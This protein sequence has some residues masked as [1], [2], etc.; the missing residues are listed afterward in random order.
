MRTTHTRVST[1]V[2]GAVLIVTLLA[3]G[4][5]GTA[6]AQQ[7]AGEVVIARVTITSSE[8]M[9]RLIGLGLDLLEHREGADLFILSTPEQVEELGA[10]GF[11]ISIDEPQTAVL[12]QQIGSLTFRD[13]YSTV[14]EMRARLEARAAQYP[15]LAEFFI[16]GSSWQKLNGQGGHDLFGIRLTNTEIPGPKPTFFLMAAIH[17][18]E[19]TV[20]ELALRFIDH[21]L[22][23]YG[24]DADATWLLDEHVVVVVPVVNPD[25]RRVAEQGY[26]QRKNMNP[27]NGFGCANPPTVTNQFGID[28]NRNYTFKWGTVNGPGEPPCGQTYPGPIP[29]SEPETDAVQGLVRSLFA[30]QRGPGDNDAAPLTTTGVLLTLHSYGDLVLWP[31]GYTGNTAPNVADLSLIGR[32]FAGYNGHTPQQS[33]QLYPT[34]GT[35]DDWSYGELGIPSFTFEVG[36]SSG[37]CGGFMPPYSCLD[38]GFNG[39]FWP[40]NLPAFLY[41][42]RIARTPYRLVRGPTVEALNLIG[43]EDGTELHATVDEQRNGGQRIAAAEYYLD[44]PPWRGGTPIPM[45]ALDGSFNSIVET[46]TTT[47]GPLSGRHIV[48]VR[49]Q[50]ELGNWGAVRAIF[51]ADS[52]LSALSFNPSEVTGGKPSVGTVTL[53]APAP[54]GGAVV[55]LSSGNTAAVT[56]PATVTVPAGETTRTFTATTKTVAAVTDV[57]VDAT[58][59]DGSVQGVLRVKPPSLKKLSVVETSFVAP[60]QTATGKV[61]LTGKAPAGGVQINLTTTNPAVSI[62][63][64]VTVPAGKTNVTFVVSAPS[65]VGANVAGL[66]RAQAA[67]PNFGTNIVSKQVTVLPNRATALA[68]PSPITGPA[69]V[70][71]TVTLTCAAGASGQVVSLSSTNA[72]IAQPVDQAGNPIS[73]MTIAAGQ[74]VGTFRVRA[75]DVSSPT[76]VKIKATVNGVVKAVSVTVN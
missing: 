20:S 52:A 32:K 21:L 71:A 4:G 62:P 28:L 74:P 37:S 11:R 67:N 6:N 13:G 34:S 47:I 48:F 50:D 17:A 7:P 53:D 19:L 27:T 55:S 72:A 57:N 41:A 44:T 1:I 56:V 35:T 9:T 58:Y 33:I 60:C 68:V 12:R 75:A 31:W 66:V 10:S 25:G 46:A 3:Q 23:G 39:L 26:Y 59:G 64:S 24:V 30:D 70:V 63:P 14:P 73:S 5:S 42:A 43:S 8:E 2:F 29:D 65:A 49:G 54:D 22:E 69:T 16:Y 18:R 40:R 15:D 38:G 76:V 45:T 51:I 61:T 36:L